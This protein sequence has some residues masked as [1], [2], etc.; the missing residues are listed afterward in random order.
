MSSNKLLLILNIFLVLSFA[1]AISAAQ[2]INAIEP[3]KLPLDASDVLEELL[4][5]EFAQIVFIDSRNGKKVLLMNQYAEMEKAADSAVLKKISSITVAGVTGIKGY[6]F[7]NYIN[8]DARTD[9][10]CRKINQDTRASSGDKFIPAELAQKLESMLA[11]ASKVDDFKIGFVLASNVDNGKFEL[12]RS[13]EYTFID[14][15]LPMTVTEITSNSSWSVITKKIN[16][17]CQDV[18][19]DGSWYRICNKSV[20]S[21]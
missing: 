5:F 7:C 19:I 1:S 11:T 8:I 6:E 9:L 21:C 15:N 18:Y 13:S 4:G 2:Q 16:P 10:I 3:Q 17:C 20:P 12:L 14:S